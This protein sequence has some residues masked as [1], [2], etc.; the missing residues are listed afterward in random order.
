MLGESD[1]EGVIPRVCRSI[2]SEPMQEGAVST[3]TIT[4]VEIFLE[5]VRDL[6]SP[7]PVGWGSGKGSQSL[8]VRE[9]PSDGP[10]VEGATA[11]DVETFEECM[12]FMEMGSRNRQVAATK[13]NESSS[14]SHAIFTLQVTQSKPLDSNMTI[15]NT[16]GN[17]R[18]AGND[19]DEMYTVVSKIN[20]VDLAGSENAASA[21]STGARLKEGAAINKSLLALGRVIKA[22]ADNASASSSS[23]VIVGISTPNNQSALEGSTAKKPTRRA[24]MFEQSS[25]SRSKGSGAQSTSPAGRKQRES[26]GGQ[27]MHHNIFLSSSENIYLSD[28][29]I[30]MKLSYIDD[31]DEYCIID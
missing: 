16:D 5:R 24:S 17:N 14:R 28:Y 11:A 6:L 25:S 29:T 30:T 20:L 27:G 4:Y 7:P 1:N 15:D 23:S 10:F 13:M 9:H 3:Y 18:L 26:F 31:T 21:G 2:M 8:K 12:A 19:D 22:L